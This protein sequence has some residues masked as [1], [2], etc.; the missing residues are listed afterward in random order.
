[1]LMLENIEAVY[2]HTSN[3]IKQVKGKIK[4]LFIIYIMTDYSN[5]LSFLCAKFKN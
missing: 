3:S 4:P 1:M 5:S 2:T